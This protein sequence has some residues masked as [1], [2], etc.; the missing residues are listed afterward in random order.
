MRAAE[1]DKGDNNSYISRYIMSLRYHQATVFQVVD[2]CSSIKTF[3]FLNNVYLISQSKHCKLIFWCFDILK[4]VLILLD[5]ITDREGGRLVDRW[6][7]KLI[8]YA[9]IYDK[10][11]K[12]SL[13]QCSSDGVPRSE[14]FGGFPWTLGVLQGY[15]VLQGEWL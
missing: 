10:K 9:N 15:R 2:V 13:A 8:L 11:W 14:A 7:T 5:W 12:F 1:K 6:I 4:E 3:V